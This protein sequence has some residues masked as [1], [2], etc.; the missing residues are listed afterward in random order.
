[1]TFLYTYDRFAIRGGTAADLNTVN[2]ILLVRELCYETDTGKGKL[3][4]G[5]TVWNDLPY[6]PGGGGGGTQW[7]VG[8]GA[9]SSGLGTDGDFYLRSSNGDVYEKAAGAWSVVAN[10][11]GPAGATGPTGA[12]GA[13]G[14]TGPAGAPGPTA[15][16]MTFGGG[17]GVNF[18]VL[19]KKQPLVVPFNHTITGWALITDN[20]AGALTVELWRDALANYPPTVADKITASAPAAVAGTDYASSTALTGWNTAGTAGDVYVPNVTAAAGVTRWTLTLY[21]TKV[22]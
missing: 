12:T 14:A 3:G 5:V 22:P 10:I 18:V 20:P 2:E 19:G 15:A 13:T 9:P 8:S 17:D 21:I 7:Y 6:L 4:D 16:G 1:M 11:K